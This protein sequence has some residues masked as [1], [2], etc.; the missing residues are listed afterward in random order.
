MRKDPNWLTAGFII[1]PQTRTPDI[2][3]MLERIQAL[4]LD[5]L[6]LL[7]DTAHCLTL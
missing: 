6:A 7:S 4:G 5:L 2:S 1:L 3:F